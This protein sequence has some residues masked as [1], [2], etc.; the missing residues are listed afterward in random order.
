MV[1]RANDGKKV[2][3]KYGF[4]NKLISFTYYLKLFFLL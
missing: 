3:Q 4:K 2:K 1:I